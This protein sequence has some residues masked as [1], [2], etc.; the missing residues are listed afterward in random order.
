MQNAIIGRCTAPA[1]PKR[2][3]RA[4]DAAARQVSPF[5]NGA[6]TTP[7]QGATASVSAGSDDLAAL[8]E[9]TKI[10]D[11]KT[12]LLAAGA[13]SESRDSSENMVSVEGG[14][15][16]GR[17]VRGLAYVVIAGFNFSVMSTCAK[18]ACRYMSPHEL[19][20]WRVLLALLINY[21]VVR[22]KKI[23]LHV[24]PEL[25]AVLFF[26]CFIG[27]VCLALSFYAVSQMVLTDAVVLMF[28]APVFT[29]IL[30]AFVL[31]E[32]IDRV[33]LALAGLSYTG[34][35]FVARPAFLFGHDEASD[36]TSKPPAAAIASA[37]GAAVTQA[38]MYVSTRKLKDVNSLLILHYL[39]LF[40]IGFSV[41]FVLVLGVRLEFSL[42]PAVVLSLVLSAVSSSLGVVFLTLGF[43]LE[44]AG[45]ASVMRNF[46][47]VFIFAMDTL[48][49]G[50]RVSGYSIIGALL[51]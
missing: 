47:V 6:D 34:M 22:V 25:R 39:S 51:I 24:D 27:T 28:T 48:L 19:G 23:D 50:E 21:I 17:R 37:F 49:L 15:S 29:F 13:S 33:D 3:R 40:G 8:L 38:L 44:R 32:P 16:R 1:S 35:F 4:K 14:A 11:A 45:V 20:L 9:S 43:Q 26:R 31:N 46:D 42:R 36:A 5:A 18:Y 41:V 2:S 12:K 30:G 10:D 7:E